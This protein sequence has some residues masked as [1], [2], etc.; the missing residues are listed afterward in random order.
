VWR[1]SSRCCR[2]RGATRA[3]ARWRRRPRWPKDVHTY[4]VKGA[5]YAYGG[6]VG[7]RMLRRKDI[8]GL[9]CHVRL[10]RRPRWPKDVKTYRGKGTLYACN[11]CSSY[12]ASNDETQSKRRMLRH[13]GLKVPCAPVTVVRV[14]DHQRRN[15]DTMCR[16][17]FNKKATYNPAHA[18]SNPS[19][20]ECPSSVHRIWTPTH[21][22]TQSRSQACK[23]KGQPELAA[24]GCEGGERGGIML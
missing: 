14:A 1:V 5:L 21:L 7:L 12:R 2:R 24:G 19:L 4:R 8:S 3:P 11:W 20:I 15:T 22:N 16:S 9:R 13:V 17:N 6:S 18:K 10:R 23:K